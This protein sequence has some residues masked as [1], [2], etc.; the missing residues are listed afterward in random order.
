MSC[1]V[2]KAGSGETAMLVQPLKAKLRQGEGDEL[3]QEFACTPQR[4]AALLQFE[5]CMVLLAVAAIAVLRWRQ[6]QMAAL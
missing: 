4:T 3:T 1:M 6:R 2:A 5:A